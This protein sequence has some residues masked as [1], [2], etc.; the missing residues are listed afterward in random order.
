VQLLFRH[1]FGFGVR[2]RA[3]KKG[4]APVSLHVADA[5]NLVDAR[6]NSYANRLK[7]LVLVQGIDCMDL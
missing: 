5:G 6:E 1:S 4:V 2:K 7:E 3:P